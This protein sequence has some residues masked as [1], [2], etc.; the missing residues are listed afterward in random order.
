M[1]ACRSATASNELSNA[2]SSLVRHGI[3]T[4]VGMSFNI[5]SRSA[6]RFMKEF[7]GYYIG[8]NVS[9]LQAVAYARSTL[10]Q[11]KMRMSRY[12]TEVELEDHVVPILYHQ[13]SALRHLD[14]QYISAQKHQVKAAALPYNSIAQPFV[15]LVGREGDLLRLEEDLARSPGIKIHLQGPPGVGKSALLMEAKQWWQTTGLF[16]QIVYVQL[17][18]A[19]FESCTTTTIIAWIAAK[20]NIDT[21][22]RSESSLISSL[23]RWSFLLVLDSMESI[24]WS[25]QGSQREHEHRFALSLKKLRNTPMVLLSR[26]VDTWLGSTIQ[27]RR[28]LESLDMSSAIAMSMNLLRRLSVSS[29][30]L[31]TQEDQS[32]FEQLIQLSRGNPLAIRILMSDLQKHLVGDPALNMA[33]HVLSLLQMRPIH[34]DIENL[35]DTRGSRAILELLNKAKHFLKFDKQHEPASERPIG[36]FG[37]HS[38]DSSDLESL[39]QSIEML[40][41]DNH[42]CLDLIPCLDREDSKSTKSKLF[43]AMAF[44]GLWHNMIY[45]VDPFINTL[46]A[47]LVARRDMPH[48]DFIKFR[49][50]ICVYT[51]QSTDNPDYV[52]H[53]LLHKD[54]FGLPRVTSQECLAVAEKAL[55]TFHQILYKDLA[56]FVTGPAE[57]VFGTSTHHFSV[58]YYALSP[59]LSLVFQSSIIMAIFPQTV[60]NDIK[61]ARDWLYRYRTDTWLNHNAIFSTS[62]SV[63]ALRQEID[64]D[65]FNH[66]C[67]FVSCQELDSWPVGHH[68]QIQYFIVQAI[69]LD[70]RRI[71]LVER[72]L[73]RFGI[74]CMQRINRIRQRYRNAQNEGYELESQGKNWKDWNMAVDLE[75]ACISVLLRAMHCRDILL[76]PMGEYA[77]Q[78]RTLSSQPMLLHSKTMDPD[79]KRYFLRI[80]ATNARWLDHLQYGQGLDAKDMKDQLEAMQTIKSIH[81]KM[82]DPN[83]LQ[84]GANTDVSLPAQ[85]RQTY[86]AIVGGKQSILY[87]AAFVLDRITDASDLALISQAVVEMENL[88]SKEVETSNSVQVCYQLHRHLA[89]LNYLLANKPLATQHRTI[90]E[91][92]EAMLEPDVAAQIKLM[93]N[94]LKVYQRNERRL[95]GEPVNEAQ[96]LER[97]LSKLKEEL[98]EA[99]TQKDHDVLKV[100]QCMDSIG[101]TLRDLGRYTEAVDQYTR[102]IEGRKLLLPAADR[103][104]LLTTFARSKLL[105]QLKR[106]DESIPDLRML[107]QAFAS[108]SDWKVHSNVTGTLGFQLFTQATSSAASI[109]ED[110]RARLLTE[111]TEIL[112]TICESLEELF[113]PGDTNI[114]IN[115]SNLAVIYAHRKSF[116]KAEALYRSAIR[117]HRTRTSNEADESLIWT[118]NSLASCCMDMRKHQDAE[119]I[120]KRILETCIDHYEMWHRTTL[121]LMAN[122]Y[123]FYLKAD[124]KSEGEAFIR[125]YI[126]RFDK[127]LRDFASVEGDTFDVLR[128]KYEFGCKLAICDSYQTA[129]VLLDE[130]STAWLTRGKKDEEMLQALKT[131][132]YCYASQEPRQLENESEVNIKIIDYS[133]SLK[134][135]EHNDTLDAMATQVVCLHKIG[136]SAEA[137]ELQIPIIE[138]RKRILGESHE[139]TITN[140]TYLAEMYAD[141]KNWS[142]ALP[143]RKEIFELRNA[144]DSRSLAAL[145]QASRLA[146]CYEN[147]QQ[148]DRVVEVRRDEYHKRREVQGAE[149]ANTFLV[150]TELAFGLDKIG[151]HSEAKTMISEAIDGRTKVLGTGHV[152]TLTSRRIKATICRNLG[153]FQEAEEIL[154]NVLAVRSKHPMKDLTRPRAIAGLSR[155]YKT[156]GQIGRAIELIEEAVDA[157]KE[158]HGGDL[159]A[160]IDDLIM[161]LAADKATME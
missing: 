117:V 141:L 63:D 110:T 102:V 95:R 65:F 86:T 44:I 52:K 98:A 116:D 146:I 78:W 72:V 42:P 120:L 143:V 109:S 150:L 113:D 134:G 159:D 114:S 12:H 119:K 147:L 89:Y 92:L 41:M 59:L 111:A 27:S 127:S 24:H 161:T 19:R 87:K 81:E 74:I 30:L 145:A 73:S 38:E 47:L 132:R 4:A 96:G 9:I 22:G 94:N 8:Q 67:R 108:M 121:I 48:D 140:I 130:I 129:I 99:E 151:Q 124:R 46:A 43:P 155:I 118:Q 153:Q 93:N 23:D 32:F 37:S 97:R 142:A 26:T 106:F 156:R 13:E 3:K 82:G 33:S 29:R 66:V 21:E 152:E 18:D 71:R 123:D 157:A 104:T 79:L 2:A 80:L 5:Y 61:V 91:D 137:I 160:Q 51:D 126:S 45:Q 70:S 69:E 10:R 28:L 34:L 144:I 54:A 68:W 62:P 64:Y 136:R 49:N 17:T 85:L 40:E 50:Q 158:L 55:S 105:G 88:L 7:Y 122:L 103:K 149:D 154:R 83:Q 115:M 133:K 135:P 128:P 16:R 138:I 100:L 14:F 56:D 60:T 139:S 131:L 77:K 148:W 57:Q 39:N 53:I 84:E 58:S 125:Q 6:D 11:N 1:N 107:Q 25:S 20:L 15:D 101:D 75:T 31:A 36:R 76:Q 35:A 90:A 112:E